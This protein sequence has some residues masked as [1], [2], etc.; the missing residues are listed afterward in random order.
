MPRLLLVLLF[1]LVPTFVAAAETLF[2]AATAGDTSTIS[3]LLDNG[4]PVD[5][6]ARDEATPLIAAA[7]AGQTEATKLLIERGA[8]IMARNSGGFTALHAAAY[9]GSM[10]VAILLLDNKAVLDDAENKA[11]VTPMFVAAEMNHPDVVE[12]LIA[13]GSDVA[14]PEAHGYSAMTRAFWKGHKGMVSLL[15]RHGLV[16][17]QDKLTASEYTQC[18]AIKG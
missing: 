13:R 9:S 11:G 8:N 3:H 12:L 7:L 4:E 15:K 2:S 17:Q 14:R 5:A 1:T 10:P 16:C 6:R 18:L